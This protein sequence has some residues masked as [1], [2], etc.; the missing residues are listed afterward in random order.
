[1]GLGAT[2]TNT[3]SL[4][5]NPVPSGWLYAETFPYVGLS[6]NLPVNGVGWVAA[7]SAG[8]S[9]IFTLGGGSGAV[10]SFSGTP[11]TKAFYTTVSND[12]GQSGLR[13]VAIDPTSVP[14][15]TLQAAFSPGN[16][17]GTVNGNVTVYWA[18]QMAGSNWYST[19][20]PIPIN[21]SAQNNYLTNQLAFT[22]V[23]SNWNNVTINGNSVTVGAQASGTLTGNITGAGMVITHNNTS[24][25]SMNWE[26]FAVTTNAV[27]TNAPTIN[28]LVGL[29]NQSVPTGGG[30]SFAVATSGGTL[31]L[32]YSWSLNGVMLTNNARISGADTP[33]L[34]IA[35][36]TTND[37]DTSVGPTGNIIAY[38][39]NSAGTDHSD[40]YFPVS[41]FVTNAPV[42]Q[43]YLESFPYV[44]PTGNRPITGAGWVQA[45]PASANTLFERTTFTGEG[46]VFAFLGSAGTTV[47]YATTANDTN[48]SGMQFPAFNPAFYSTLTFSVDIA[49]STAPSNVAAYLAV[50][51]G[52]NWYAS[53]TP[54]PTPTTPSG[55]YTTYTT[56]FSAA[57]ANW[58]NLVVTSSGGAIQGPATGNLTGL[59]TG[60]GLAFKTI[61]TGGTFDFDNFLIT[62]NGVGGINVGPVNG[63][64]FNL[65]W[66][67]NPA[68]NLQTITNIAATNWTD[69]PNSAGAYSMPVNV[70]EAKRFFRLVEHQ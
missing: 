31:P 55:T 40:L 70:N 11:V 48:Q 57:A 12:V 28:S 49:P 26:N 27:I 63:G 45:M 39:A 4:T 2:N 24:G 38:V 6:G 64:S 61:G 21:I 43:L 8:T 68:V 20:Q 10:F 3:F 9:G 62:G 13:F 52:T 44:G 42:G 65:S 30:A 54:F 32:T 56:N 66:V 51:M 59:M 41:L 18:V 33:T 46:A 16:G 1:V 34:T 67:G 69:V 35:N 50:R 14:A 7:Q 58:S 29:Y 47:Y 17:A 60:A 22:V 53:G 15:V 37:T 5:V 36:C 19:V 23:A 25:A